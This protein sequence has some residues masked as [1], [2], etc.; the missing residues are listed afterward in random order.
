MTDAQELTAPDAPP[1]RPTR[2]LGVTSAVFALAIVVGGTDLVAGVSALSWRYVVILALMLAFLSF[3]SLG[4]GIVPLNFNHLAI[5]VFGVVMLSVALAVS[6]SASGVSEH[7]FPGRVEVKTSNE[8]VC[9][10]ITSMDHDFVAIT[11]R[12]ASTGLDGRPAIA[13]VRILIPISAIESIS[14]AD[15]C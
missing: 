14:S 2:W 12:K 9:G 5:A 11:V 13:P 4:A 10:D 8:S 7:R 3:A 15:Y 1:R 6:W